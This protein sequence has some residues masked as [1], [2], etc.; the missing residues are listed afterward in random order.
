M[1]YQ[2]YVEDIYVEDNSKVE[3]AIENRFD[4]TLSLIERQIVR[5]EL[6]NYN[7]E[8]IINALDN[9]QLN[10]HC[11]LHRIVVILNFQNS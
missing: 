7:E 4:R 8:D 3:L 5:E 10:E 1:K 9:E 2:K 6:C 11:S